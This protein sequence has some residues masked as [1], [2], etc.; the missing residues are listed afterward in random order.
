MGA[1][2]SRCSSRHSLNSLSANFWR[3]KELI[4]SRRLSMLMSARTESGLSGSTKAILGSTSGTASSVIASAVM[5]SP[6]SGSVIGIP[7]V[8]VGASGA[9]G[10][11]SSTVSAVISSPVSGSIIGVAA[12]SV[13]PAKISSSS[14][15]ISRSIADGPLILSS[16]FCNAKSGATDPARIPPPPMAPLR[17][18][19]HTR[20]NTPGWLNRSKTLPRSSSLLVAT[21]AK[22]S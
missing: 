7:S 9:G 3:S 6:V 18:A 2:P 17:P 13:G 10:S 20:S 11:P 14:D 22:T 21:I 4:S 16:N 19:S 5:G 15:A 1:F 12:G 8:S